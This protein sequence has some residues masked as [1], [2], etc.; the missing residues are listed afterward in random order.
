MNEALI[1]LGSN[2]GDR[3]AHL[4]A[5]CLGMLQN[6][7]NI[8]SASSLYESNPVGYVS[9]NPFL[10]A[11]VHVSTGLNAAALMTILQTIEL[12][13]GRQKTNQYSDRP[14]DIDILF[15]GKECINLEGLSIPHP[16]AH[17][18]GFVL[19]PAVEIAPDWQHPLLGKTLR[20]LLHGLN[21]DNEGIRFFLASNW[22]HNV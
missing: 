4:R 22:L 1:G 5:G 14:L 21:V 15:M 19:V 10:N 8:L 13:A 18:R 12:Q 11:V 2:L 16:R 3:P 6:G 7:I 17:L 20:E 9:S